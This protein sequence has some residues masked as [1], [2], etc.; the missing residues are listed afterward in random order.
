MAMKNFKEMGFTAAQSRLLNLLDSI[1]PTEDFVVPIFLMTGDSDEDANEMY[2]I[3]KESGLDDPQAILKAIVE[4]VR[5][6][7]ES[8]DE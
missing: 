2:E 7:E 5:E 4:V 3:I 1:S 6:S 8:E